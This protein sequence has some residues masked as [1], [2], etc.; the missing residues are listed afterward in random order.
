MTVERKA[1]GLVSHLFVCPKVAVSYLEVEAGKRCSLH[2]HAHRNNLFW[3]QSGKILVE[4]FTSPEG[5]LFHSTELSAGDVVVVPPGV[6]HRF[7]VLESGVVIEAYWSDNAAQ[8]S[9]DDIIRAD[10]GGDDV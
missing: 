5:R 10:V 3:V 4:Q 9:L 1:W 8:L 2:Y 7:R 6:W